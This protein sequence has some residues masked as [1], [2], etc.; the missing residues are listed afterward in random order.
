M[1][2]LLKAAGAGDLAEVQRLLREGASLTE[3]GQNGMTAL[4]WAVKNGHFSLV[5]WLIKESGLSVTEVDENGETAL[6]T[7]LVMAACKGKYMLVQWLLEEGKA[8]INDRD[9]N[10]CDI[11]MNLELLGSTDRPAELSSLLKVMVLLVD[12]P[13]DFI[14]KLLPQHAE[15]ATRGRLIRALRPAYLEQQRALLAAHCPLLAVLFPLVAAYAVP[16]SED[17]WTDWVQWM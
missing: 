13:S 5:R 4:L 3:M 8:S 6:L 10:D 11:W 16:T 7:A 17:M 14:T 2:G 1:P 15:L 12:A 9:V